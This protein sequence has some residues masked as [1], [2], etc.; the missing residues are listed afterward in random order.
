[1]WVLYEYPDI[2]PEAINPVES[3]PLRQK[4]HLV[5]I[6]TTAGTG[7]EATWAIVLTDEVE[8]RKLGLGNRSSI[9]D[10]AI[11]DPELIMALPPRLTA[12]TG[13]DALTHAI[14][15][16]TTTWHNDFS[17]GLCLKAAQLVFE[18]LPRLIRTARM[19]RHARICRMPPRLPGWGLAIRW[20][21]WRTAWGM[22]W[23]LF[24]TCRTG[25]A[26]QVTAVYDRVLH[27]RRARLHPLPGTGA[28]YRPAGDE[29]RARSRF[30][31]AEAVRR[32]H[33]EGSTAADPRSLRHQPEIS[34]ESQTCSSRMP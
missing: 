6:P 18:F 12:D 20:L 23:A 1:M 5:A 8:Q 17:D 4:A 27:G 16:Y 19:L 29:G 26:S 14:E 15:G 32:L 28:F 9:P 3:L 7:S 10:L 33:G 13:L 25:A 24:S 30:A 31:L 2:E 21:P 34:K 11:L 22:P